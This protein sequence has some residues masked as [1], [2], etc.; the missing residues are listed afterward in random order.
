MGVR[1]IAR[2]RTSPRRSGGKKSAAWSA[3]RSLAAIFTKAKNTK[4][5]NY[6]CFFLLRFSGNHRDTPRIYLDWLATGTGWD[7]LKVWNWPHIYLDWLATGTRWERLGLAGPLD[8]SEISRPGGYWP[9]LLSQ[10]RTAGTG[11]T[12]LAFPDYPGIRLDCLDLAEIVRDCR[13]WLGLTGQDE[14]LF[15]KNILWN[16]M[17]SQLE[18]L[19]FIKGPG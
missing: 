13:I 16:I 19:N 17:Q 5:L 8:L 2:R 4:C 12:W 9:G 7:W 1:E 6:N 14:R 11:W 15:W 18:T 3:W 10:P